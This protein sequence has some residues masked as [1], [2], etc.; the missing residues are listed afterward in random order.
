MV[1]NISENGRFGSLG[2]IGGI[3][4]V[5]ILA[6]CTAWHFLVA[7][8]SVAPDGRE[9][10]VVVQEQTERI[11]DLEDDIAAA[12]HSIEVRRQTAADADI[13]AHKLELA[14]SENSAR[15]KSVA[16][17]KAGID[18]LESDLK[19]YKDDYREGVWKSAAGEKLPS[20]ALKSGRRYDNVTIVRVT[21]GGME[22]SHQDG[23][24]RISPT[25]LDATWQK[26]F[27]WD[28]SQ[29]VH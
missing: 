24:A 11:R 13:L 19:S 29:P 4:F 10:K 25:D 3:S 2:V 15:I 21:A 20:L 5:F 18:R 27:Q 14:E 23:L 6:V 16:D 28:M 22:I 17:L 12:K 26:R 7:N 9:F 1:Q 8:D